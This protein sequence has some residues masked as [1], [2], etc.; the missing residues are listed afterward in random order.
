MMFD[1]CN[2]YL[3]TVIS[4]ESMDVGFWHSQKPTYKYLTI[5]DSTL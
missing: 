5:H 1:H 4:Q 3:I 2:L